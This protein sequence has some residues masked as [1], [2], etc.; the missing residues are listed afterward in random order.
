MAEKLLKTLNF[1]TGDVYHPAPEWENVQNKPFGYGEEKILVDNQTLTF[2]EGECAIEGI[3]LTKGNAYKVVMD[4]V[5]SI[6]ICDEYFGMFNYIGNLE[7]ILGLEVTDGKCDF[8]IFGMDSILG[9]AT[10]G[11]ET[12][13]ATLTELEVHKIEKHFYESDLTTFY[14]NDGFDGIYKNATCTDVVTFDEFFEVVRKGSVVFNLGGA[15]WMT[16]VTI[17]LEQPYVR[18]VLIAGLNADGTPACKMI[19]AELP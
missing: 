16:P 7:V 6:H 17:V 12:A 4:G 9:F 19:E 5:E 15:V 2:E 18:V 3:T 13:V 10:V 14:V 1:G 11:K 8:G